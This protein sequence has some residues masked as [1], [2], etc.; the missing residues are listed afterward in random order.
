[1]ID[2]ITNT[3]LESFKIETYPWDA[4]SDPS[5]TYDSPNADSDPQEVIFQ[6]TVDTV[7]STGVFLSP[8][9]STVLP[10]ATWSCSVSALETSAPTPAPA[11]QTV[12]PTPEPTP[13]PTPSPTPGPTVPPTSAPPTKIAPASTR[14]VQLTPKD[15]EGCMRVNGSAITSDDNL[16]LAT[17]IGPPEPRSQLF[18][19][20]VRNQIR[21]A[22]NLNKCLT[23]GV[24]GD[25]LDG[26]P[27][28][29]SDCNA[30][31]SFQQF[32]FDSVN[33]GPISLLQ[34]PEYCLVFSTNPPVLDE[35]PIHISGC[36]NA[37]HLSNGWEVK[38]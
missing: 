6:L 13:E 22:N 25:T 18:E 2:T 1:M 19:L 16:L 33:G 20:A 38:K 31:N 17:C 5:P 27:V 30:T 34:F 8:D 37:T 15:F 12:T 9:S 10:V 24:S 29:V 4:G 7:P 32:T 11:A 26:S 35:E 3:W 21:P 14:T 36:G 28:I 23:G